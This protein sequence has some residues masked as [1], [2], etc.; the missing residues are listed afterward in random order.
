MYYRDDLPMMQ[1]ISVVL[2]F[3]KKKKN[4]YNTDSNKR[5]TSVLLL[6]DSVSKEQ[7]HV[8]C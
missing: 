7:K 8:F 1:S 6:S 5:Y 4:K 3:Q 2:D